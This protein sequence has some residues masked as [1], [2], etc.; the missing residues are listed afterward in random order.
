MSI[1]IKGTAICLTEGL[2][3]KPNAKTTH[4]LLRGTKR[5]EIKGIIDSEM[6][7]DAG[8]ALDGKKVGIDFY[9][10]INHFLEHNEPVDYCIIGVATAGGVLLP[11]FKKLVIAALEKNISVI[12]GLHS[13][14][15][16]DAEIIE[17][18]KKTEAQVFDIRKPKPAKDLTFWSGKIFDV[19]QKKIGVIGMDCAI[20][21]RTSSKM[22]VNEINAKGRHAEMIYTGQTG[23]ME[24]WDHGFIFD[25]TLNDFVSGEMEKAIVECSEK[26]KPDVIIIEGQSALRNYSG[27]CGSEIL[28]SA[29]V[30]GVI[31]VYAPG[32]KYMKGWDHLNIKMPSLES[33]IKLIEMYERKV[34]GVCLNT[35]WLE[36]DEAL[37]L[38]KEY[39]E[40]FNIP[41]DIPMID[42]VSKVSQSILNI[43][44]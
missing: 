2:F 10:S 31:L 32:R 11:E 27:P 35:Q 24:G 41:V 22:I 34:L 28:L 33:E 14:L 1:E 43:I 21:K 36:K 16:D 12:N 4:G 30:D 13:Y 26:S 6:E 19:P 23:W 25:S 3:K 15:R 8:E 38:Q 18:L 37:R 44:N 20:G 42:G 29:N 9:K 5:F 39:A 40:Q 17:I 7:G